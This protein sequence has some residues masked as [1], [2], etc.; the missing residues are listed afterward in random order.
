MKMKHA[1]GK[2]VRMI[3]IRGKRE[4]QNGKEYNGQTQIM[5]MI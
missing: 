3:S 1:N 5:H 4:E 2:T